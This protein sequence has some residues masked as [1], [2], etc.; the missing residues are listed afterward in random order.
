MKI[1]GMP[2]L[3]QA[4]LFYLHTIKRVFKGKTMRK[5]KK[6]ENMHGCIKSMRKVP[7]KTEVYVTKEENIMSR[8]QE[9]KK[10]RNKRAHNIQ[11]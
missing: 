6:K 4:K 9:N 3:H 7:L 1:L 10:V 2:I 8:G 11:G 5:V